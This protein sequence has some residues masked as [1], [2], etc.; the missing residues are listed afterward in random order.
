MAGPEPTS[1]LN[2]PDPRAAIAGDK[3]PPRATRANGVLLLLTGAAEPVPDAGAGA[4]AVSVALAVSVQLPATAAATAAAAAAG[5]ASGA[6][7]ATAAAAATADDAVYDGREARRVQHEV[8]G[9]SPRVAEGAATDR[10]GL[11]FGLFFSFMFSGKGE[12]LFGAMTSE[13]WVGAS[14]G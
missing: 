9:A 6:A 8:G 10:V 2:L 1:S 5:R 13:C 3:P 11:L 4:G 7:S 14:L 12:C